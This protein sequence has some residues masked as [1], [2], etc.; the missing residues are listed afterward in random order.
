VSGVLT[1]GDG[2][3]LK[4]DTI[5]LLG[6]AKF[7]FGHLQKHARVVGIVEDHGSVTLD[8]DWIAS[9]QLPIADRTFLKNFE[10]L[11]RPYTVHG[12]FI[13]PGSSFDSQAP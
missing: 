4:L 10:D 2:G 3:R 7:A 5:G 9:H 13:W 6:P 12:S 11:P 1:V 8:P